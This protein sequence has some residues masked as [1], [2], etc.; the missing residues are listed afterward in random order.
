MILSRLRRSRGATSTA[1]VLA[2]L[3]LVLSSCT[4]NV[5]WAGNADDDSTSSGAEQVQGSYKA[6]IRRTEGGVAHIEGTSLANVAFGQGWASAE[7]RACDLADQV[8]KVNSERAMYLG[9]GEDNANL[10]SDFAWLTV[11]IRKISEA[12]WRTTTRETREL[13]RAYV[14]GWNKQ[15]KETGVENIN[16]WC[17]GEE[18][19]KPLTPIDVYTYARSIA[20]LASSGA[21]IDMIGT[22]QPPGSTSA[23]TTTSTTTTVA[24]TTTTA[25]TG[26]AMPKLAAQRA[27]LGSNGWAIG[28]DRTEDQTGMLLANPHF[29][30]EGELRFWEVHLTVPGKINM[31]GVQLSGIPGIGIGFNEKFGWTHTVSAGYRMTA[32]T[33]DLVK[34]SPTKYIYGDET[35]DLV[36]T[37]YTIKVRGEDGQLKDETR[38]TWRSHY[39][40]VLDFPG[41]GWSDDQTVTFRD[42]NID[43][44]EF[45]SQ[46]IAMLKVR[47]LDGLKELTKRFTGVPLFNTIAVSDDGRAW[48]ADT[49]ATPNLSKEAQDAYEKSLETDFMVKAASESGAILLDGSNPLFEWQLAEGARDPGL[50]PYDDMPMV[51][52]DDYVFNANDSFWMPNARHMIEGDYSIL[53]GAQRT[54]RSPRTRENATVLES[55]G[56]SGPAGEDQKFSLKELENAA[57]QNRGFTSRALKDD[58]VERCTGAPAVALD[59]LTSEDNGTLPAATIDITEACKLLAD[60]DGRYDND[61]VGAIIWREFMAKYSGDDQMDAGALWAL[62]FDFTKPVQTPSGLAGTPGADDPVLT[63]LARSVQALESVG[64]AIDTPLGEVQFAYRNGTHVPV[65]GGTGADGTTNI[66][67]WSPSFHTLDPMLTSL[68]AKRLAPKTAAIQATGSNTDGKE[69]EMTGYPVIFGTSFLMALEFTDSGP[70]ADTFLTYGNIANRSDPEYIKATERYSKKQWKR[71]QFSDSDVRRAAESTKTVS[72]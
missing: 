17:A 70:V 68:N 63:N 48:Y 38:T 5:D 31:Y 12:D 42:A 43:D 49:A 60:W 8:I 50:V 9:P 65:H 71:A 36:P 53:H 3:A 28:K 7:D 11:G 29:P 62:P 25:P 10:D 44:D 72:G 21:L 2:T 40:P 1:V 18:W 47:D 23:V 39:G 66:A 14:A 22:A 69:F 33:L 58:V 41:V 34:G 57:L 24:P 55:D 67:A 37:D 13:F 52:R 35:K 64:I 19:V 32:Y 45:I 30:W 20:V 51:E 27:S 61:S 26:E 46:Y 15:I 16:D 56:N 59:E 4:D 6:T 54:S